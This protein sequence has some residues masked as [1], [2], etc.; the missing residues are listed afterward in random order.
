MR[1]VGSGGTGKSEKIQTTTE[2]FVCF[3]NTKKKKTLSLATG[4]RQKRCARDSERLC[5][6]FAYCTKAYS[7]PKTLSSSAHRGDLWVAERLQEGLDLRGYRPQRL[8]SALEERLR[9]R[10]YH[11]QHTI[12]EAVEEN[13]QVGV[14][15][16]TQTKMGRAKQMVLGLVRLKD[17]V[18]GIEPK[19]RPP[20]I[21]S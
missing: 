19:A 17:D 2:V 5:R 13:E 4:I 12:N 21:R 14:D 15:Q 18:D 7:W 1:E 6:R 8:R 3:R 9:T 10:T 11:T 20:R 16:R